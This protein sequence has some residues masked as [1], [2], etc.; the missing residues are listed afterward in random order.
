MKQKYF[1][2]LENLK[3]GEATEATPNDKVLIIDGLNTFIRSFAVSPVTNDN[4]VHVGGIT[5]FLM[6]IGY[7]IRTIQPTRSTRIRYNN[8]TSSSSGGS[9]SGGGY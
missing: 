2:I 6:S 7:A 9:S 8:N 4:G 5:G 3:E 1:S